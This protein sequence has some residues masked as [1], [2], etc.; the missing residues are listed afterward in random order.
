MNTKTIY[1]LGFFDGVHIGHGALLR[2][3]KQLAA[4]QSCRC[5]AVTFTSHPDGLVSGTAPKL[6]NTASDR[7]MLMRQLYGMDC[8]VELPFDNAMRNTS[9]QSFYRMLCSRYGAAGFVC[10]H[11]FR[12]G[13]GGEGTAKL[14][15]EICAKDGIPCMVIPEQKLEG[16]TVSSSYIRSLLLQGD[17][18][19]AN[20]FLGHPHIFTGTV[21]PGQQLGRTLGTPTANLLLPDTLLCPKFGVYAC[22]ARLENYRYPAVTNIGCR[23]TVGGKHVTVEAWLLGY[24]GDLYGKAFTLEFHSFLREEKKFAS[25]AALQEEIQKNAA[26]T[27]EFFQ[28]S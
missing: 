9:W 20:A 28:K 4:A 2:A 27:L 6:I 10:G 23:P 7:A 16:T 1:A 11:D 21:V 22:M 14:L 25:L 18:R 17:I 8:I 19:R 24:S 13:K 26:Q 5:G 3:C 15:Q 12:F